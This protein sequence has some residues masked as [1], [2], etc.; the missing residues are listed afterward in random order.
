[1]QQRL[2]QLNAAFPSLSVE[3][4][5]FILAMVRDCV[6]ANPKPRPNLTL[7]SGRIERTDVGALRRVGGG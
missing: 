2:N 5:I 3:D 6:K 4:Q 7:I 1:M